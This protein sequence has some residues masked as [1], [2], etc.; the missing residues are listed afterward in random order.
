MDT[1][2]STVHWVLWSLTMNTETYLMSTVLRKW[3]HLIPQFELTKALLI[4]QT[5]VQ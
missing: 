4:D 2:V 3:T 1:I 5:V